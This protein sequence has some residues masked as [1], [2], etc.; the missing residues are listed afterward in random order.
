MP[1]LH[2]IGA[3]GGKSDGSFASLTVR[4]MTLL[5]PILSAFGFSWNQIAWANLAALPLNYFLETGLAFMLAGIWLRR[6]W[7]RK[8]IRESEGIALGLFLTALFVRRSW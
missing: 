8:R 3:A 7:R 1:Y 5:E 4:S 2:G 6:A